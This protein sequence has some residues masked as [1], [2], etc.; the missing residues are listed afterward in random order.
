MNIFLLNIATNGQA[1]QVQA[2]SIIELRTARPIADVEVPLG[3]FPGT[4]EPE[5]GHG[6]KLLLKGTEKNLTL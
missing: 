5:K 6:G 3:K 4:P 1:Y 2:P